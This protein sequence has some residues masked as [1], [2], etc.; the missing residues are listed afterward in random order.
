M[1]QRTVYNMNFDW[2]FHDGD[3]EKTGFEC[4]HD[5]R[6]LD[7]TYLK[8]GNC[9]IAKY[10]YDDS[11][12]DQVNVPHDFRVYR[13]EYDPVNIP[14]PEGF[15]TV[16]IVWY[17]KSFYMDQ[18]QE[19]K[20]IFIEFDGVYRNSE[21]YVNG[22]FVG[23]HLSG[24]TS[25]SFEVSDVILY[26]QPNVVAVK[27]NADKFEG[28]WYEAAGIYRDVRLV[29]TDRLHVVKDGV[30]IRAEQATWTQHGMSEDIKV[31]E[32]PNKG[33]RTL[34][35]DIE[36]ANDGDYE[37]FCYVTLNV[38]DPSG[39]SVYSGKKSMGMNPYSKGSLS[40]VGRLNQ[41]VLWDIDAPNLYSYD[42]AVSHDFDVT[43]LIRGNFGI[44]DTNFTADK[45]IFLNG[46]PIKIQGV[47]VHDDFAAV[48]G[49]MTESVIR[50]KVQILKD[51]GCNAYRCSHNPPSPYL[52]KACDEIGLLVMDEVRL[53]S[54]AD[55]YLQQMTDLFR[56][57]RNHAS[58]FIW[59]IGNEE[60]N[61]HGT[62]TGVRIMKK[63]QRLAHELDDTRP[64]TYANN[65]NWNEITRFHEA[66]EC[67]IDV[68]GF[69]Y[70][71]MRQFDL[72]ADIHKDFPDRCIIG[73]ENGSGQST[74]G[75]YLPRIEELNPDYYS[76]REKSTAIWANPKRKYNV[77]AYGESYPLWGST[78]LETI[79]AADKEYVSGYFVW[80][81]FDYRG[82]IFPFTWPSTIARY[83]IIDICGFLKDTGHQYRVHWTKTPAIHL[84][85]HWTFDCLGEDIEVVV[86]ANTEEIEFIC[87][88]KSYGRQKLEAYQA[89]HYFVTY[90]PGEVVAIGYNGGE[91]VIRE[92]H[93]SAGVPTRVALEV[94]TKGEATANG[95]DHIYVKVSVLDATGTTHMASNR[96]INFDLVGEGEIVGSGNG[97]PLCHDHDFNHERDLFNGLAVVV[98]KT[99]RKTGKMTLTAA[100][101]GLEAAVLE[102]DV[103]IPAEDMLAPE[104]EDAEVITYDVKD[105]ADGGV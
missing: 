47:C 52:L 68:F 92:S 39:K 105:A 2:Q 69:N 72:Y 40:F 55:E 18:A 1:S 23:R 97:D 25:F 74:R 4:V 50:H 6:F 19:G 63:L 29:M 101:D 20:N 16:G 78:P 3:I 85:P 96:H 33:A 93:K 98:L 86:T 21:V 58:I 53:M 83:G 71:V 28:W 43:D 81:G 59:S 30:F 27:V 31:S 64:V 17:R 75:Q 13:G 104:V 49:A 91:E 99:T 34:L 26:D 87:N 57:D 38:F 51:M 41:S 89:A 24:Y 36:I 100:S 7:P 54:T 5:T 32:G 70:Y 82:E 37:G 60:M 15:L 45:G 46:R 95:E 102:I 94:M 67:H 73:T 48:G 56:R 11:G 44:K 9:G 35:A 62:P 80:T 84:M 103:L 22:H 76:P 42:V 65:A 90:E 66:N 79:K 61:I 77:S 88:G 8:A 12:W 14:E 10:G